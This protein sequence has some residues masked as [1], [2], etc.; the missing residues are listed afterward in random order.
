MLISGKRELD[1][2]KKINFVRMAG[3][4]SELK[5]AQIIQQEISAIGLDGVIEPF[6]IN[7]SITTAKLVVTSPYRKEYAVTGHKRCLST[8]PEGEEFDFLYAENLHDVNLAN[9]KNKFV[10]VNG[11]VGMDGYKKLIKAGVA[12]FI[13]MNG[14]LLDKTDETDLPQRKIRATLASQGLTRALTIRIADAFDMVKRGATR[15]KVTIDNQNMDLTSHNV[16]CQVDGTEYPEE[17]ISFG[18]HYD[19]V[20]FSNGAY[21]NAAGS[22]ILLELLRYFKANPPKRTVRFHW[23]GSEEIGLEGSKHFVTAHKDELKNH[24]LMINVDLAGPILGYEKAYVMAEQNLVG[25]ADYFFKSKGY[26]VKVE[27]NIYSSDSIPFTDNKVPAI[28]FARIGTPGG[29]YIHE[30]NDVIKYVS[31]D[32]LLNTTKYV[33]DFSLQL[34][35]AVAFPVSEE[36]PME[37][38]EKIDKY[39]FKKELE[40]AKNTTI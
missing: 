21:D 31:A 2:I 6:T 8:S 16:Y 40:G 30:R 34:I 24:K 22:A 37:I 17:I 7:D 27:S 33:L 4:E 35:N 28:N 19:S 25:Y 3:T 29:I 11:N 10:L 20:K 9:A 12:G 36:I 32:K 5:A 13:T 38:T 1:F 23:Y 14:T 26:P 39:L 15:V 18:A